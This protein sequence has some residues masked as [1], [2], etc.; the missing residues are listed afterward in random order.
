M[1]LKYDELNKLPTRKSNLVDKD[2]HPIVEDKIKNNLPINVLF[3][4]VNE[5]H[6]YING[7]QCYVVYITGILE[8]S[9]KVVLR[10]TNIPVYFIYVFQMNFK[11]IL[12]IIN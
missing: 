11:I 1:Y 7:K 3:N 2:I 10:V 4:S 12:K 5:K 9:S 6:E 8:D